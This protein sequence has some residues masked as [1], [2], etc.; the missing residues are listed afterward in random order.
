MVPCRPRHPSRGSLP[1]TRPLSPTSSPELSLLFRPTS[2][3]RESNRICQCCSS[4]CRAR[5]FTVRSS[6]CSLQIRC[7]RTYWLTDTAGA[8][9]TDP[10]FAPAPA[11]SR[12][13]IPTRWSTMHR[14]RPGASSSLDFMLFL[15]TECDIFVSLPNRCFFQLAGYPATERLS[16]LRPAPVEGLTWLHDRDSAGNRPRKR[17]LN[18]VVRDV[19]SK[20]RKHRRSP[21]S[22]LVV[23]QPHTTATEDIPP[24]LPKS[25][26]Q[27]CRKPSALLFGRSTMLYARA[28]QGHKGRTW[29]GLPRHHLLSKSVPGAQSGLAAIAR[30]FPRLFGLDNVFT[31]QRLDPKMANCA[32]WG[33]SESKSAFGEAPSARRAL[34]RLRSFLPLWERVLR[35]HQRTNYSALLDRHCTSPRS[36]KDDQRVLDEALPVGRVVAFIRAAS[37]RV[38][39]SAV[40]GGAENEK[41][42]LSGEVCY[43][44]GS[45]VP[46]SQSQPS[47]ASFGSDEMK[48]FPCTTSARELRSRASRGCSG[49]N[50]SHRFRAPPTSPTTIFSPKFCGGLFRGS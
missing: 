6:Y 20:R 19:P 2:F 21:L 10:W 44:P 1:R 14:P 49:T 11:R 39:P 17:T 31:S 33:F 35:N 48:T 8:R 22:P 23:D 16:N 43:P 46:S 28:A 5:S 4:R 32:A 45:G 9:N 29:L 37:K 40:W 25:L 3:R 26:P 38:F 50:A 27:F 30:V 47:T 34:K 12:T 41:R 13:S 42:V 7:G 18:N 36:G 15:L 24:Q